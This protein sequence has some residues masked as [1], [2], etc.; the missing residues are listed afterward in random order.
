[1]QN[2]KARIIKQLCARP[3]ARGTID[4]HNCFTKPDSGDEAPS[5]VDQ[6]QEMKMNRG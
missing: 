4:G 2:K 3:S 5:T 1:M 6:I